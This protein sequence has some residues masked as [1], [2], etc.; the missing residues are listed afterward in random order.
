[1]MMVQLR[2]SI[3]SI[4]GCPRCPSIHWTDPF[5]P[6]KDAYSTLQG[7][8]PTVPMEFIAAPW[9]GECTVGGGGSH[10]T[11]ASASMRQWP[12]HINSQLPL[13]TFSYL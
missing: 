5:S 11:L 10:T 9:E 13:T 4:C 1:M 2:Y 3:V 12:A 7:R 6:W 8:R